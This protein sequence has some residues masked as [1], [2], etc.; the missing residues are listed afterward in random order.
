ML[1]TA[2]PEK[3][4]DISTLR[5][6]TKSLAMLDAIICSEWEY[7]YYSYNSKWAKGEEMASMRNGCGDGWFVLF[8]DNGAALKGLAHESRLARDSAFAKCIQ[9]E[10]PSAFKAFLHEPAFSMDHASFCVWRRHSDSK[11]NIVTQSGE[12]PSSDLDGSAELM[13]ILEG[14]AE[15]YRDWAADYHERDIPLEAVQALYSHQPLDAH[16][17]G[18]LNPN[19]SLSEIQP[20]TLEIGYPIKPQA[21]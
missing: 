12:K 7:R 18:L 6:L 4:P 1:S 9:Q 19:L 5:R 10:V 2:S 3:L 15:T 20:D 17:L 8:D 14:R 11:W 16:V 21:S 13:S